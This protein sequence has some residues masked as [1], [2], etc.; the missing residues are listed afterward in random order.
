VKIKL[1]TNIKSTLA[2]YFTPVAVYEKLRES[3]PGSLLLES[4]DYHARE[5]H[6]SYICCK[7][8][9]KFSVEQ[10][11]ICIQYPQTKIQKIA[12]SDNNGVL[13]AFEDFRTHF[14]IQKQN[15][16]FI[17]GGFF[18]YSSYDAVQYFEDIQITKKIQR[19]PD[20]L[21]QLFQ[22][23]IVF[24]H[25]QEKLYIFE[26]QPDQTD[27]VI[28]DIFDIIQNKKATTHFFQAT[29][30]ENSNYTDEQFL[31]IIEKGIWHCQRGDVFQVVLSRKFSQSFQG[32]EWNVYRILRSINP[33]PYLFY[34]D[35]G[36]FKIFGSSP[37]TQIIIKENE[38]VI[39]PI[40]GTFRRTGDDL[41][42]AK[43]AKELFN[44]TKESAE[45]CM[46]VDLAR[47]D[48]SKQCLEVKVKIFK[49]IQYY[50]HVIHMVSKVVGRAKNTNP[51]K[52]F[53]DTFPAGT[54]SGAPKYRAMEIIDHLEDSNRE[55]YGGAIGFFSFEG[56]VNH[57]ITI[58][59]ILSY[60]GALHYQ[61]GGGIVCLSDKKSELQEANSK[62][63]AL[64]LAI[65]Q[66][67]SFFGKKAL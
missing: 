5:N 21:Y 30:G 46:L 26:Y 34:F 6:Y 53:A 16:P 54:L 47:N 22:I 20:M 8:I 19:I 41:Q 17:T 1:K 45:H 9:A 38:I 37:E 63:A 59:S 66:A 32:D 12:I 36:D 7:P 18:G 50:S 40:A 60:Q 28:A 29:A 23:V 25:F 39:Y 61:A 14:Q 42:D 43:L 52:S 4:S 55:F 57:A 2:D 62:R 58:R 64:K 67:S 15:Y 33:S 49:E 10:K 24:D 35:Y 48:L 27:S 31:E 3:Y 56:E 11:Q 44:N 65:E 51:V 13:P